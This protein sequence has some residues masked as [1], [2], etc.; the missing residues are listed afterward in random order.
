MAESSTQTAY[1]L[2]SLESRNSQDVQIGNGESGQGNPQPE[3][4]SLPP[5]DRGREAYLALM[6][7]TVAQAPIWGY[8]V[9]F[10]IFQEYY[11]RP[12]SPIGNAS[13]GEIATI[14]AL[15]MGIMYLMM[16][17]AF[18][19][20]TR[21]PRLRHWCGPLGLIVTTAS[22]TASAFVSTLPG[23]IAT[24]GGLYSLGCGLL[25]CPI[26]HY[27]NEWF[28]E[29]KGLALGIMW[30][31]KSATGVVMPFVF[32]ALLGH[33]GLRATILS[34]AVA[35]GLMTL[36]TLLFIKPRIPLRTLARSRSLSFNFLR[37]PYFWMI[38]IGIIIQAL[39]YLM[40]STYLASY[41]S[42]I[43][44]PAVTGPVLLALFSIASVP[45]GIIHGLL[46]DKLSATKVI[47]ISSVGSALPI[48]LLWGLS[49]NIGNLVVFVILYG[50][51]AGG[52]SST[53][54]SMSSEIQ[55]HDSAADSSLIFGMLLGG[56]GVGFVIAGPVSGALI[57][58]KES[59]QGEA[60]GY[61]TRYGPM[62][63]CTGITALLG[64]W[65]PLWKGAG[66][67]MARTCWN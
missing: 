61:A 9:S 59:L 36:P 22:L 14:G 47:I 53:W 56:R 3:A 34:W 15:Q 52:F 30:A 6:C 38:Q 7:C 43:G 20:L 10:G 35:S 65:A 29:R 5:T 21:Y 54:S 39:G 17:V 24:Q 28:I 57:Q 23:L 13:S 41:A 8:S 46:G 11:S 62:I 25:F 51:F 19:A 48:F 50:F 1:A 32:D 66:T 45:G 64:A 60:L 55:R 33:I 40:P 26:S 31:G 63:I 4:T 2:R 44:L 18:L 37:H 27:M 16:P 12:N 67:I 58:A 49:L 42:T